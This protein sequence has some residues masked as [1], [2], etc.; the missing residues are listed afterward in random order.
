[1]RS[2]IFKTRPG[3]SAD[4]AGR[5]FLGGPLPIAPAAIGRVWRVAG[6]TTNRRD[7]NPFARIC[8]VK[9]EDVFEPRKPQKGTTMTKF[10]KYVV[11]TA[12]A[13][14]LPAFAMGQGAAELDANGDGVLTIDEVQAVYP[15]ITAESF[16]SMDLNADG[17]LDD[18]E[19]VNAQKAGSVPKSPS[20]G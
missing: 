9:A 10:T 5:V 2:L 18:A 1:M 7:A 17:A 20:E 14:A 16:S 4:L 12:A 6:K 3:V 8:S 15:E 11:A 13:V 19:I